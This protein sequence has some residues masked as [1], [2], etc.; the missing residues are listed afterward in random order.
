MLDNGEY[1]SISFNGIDSVTSSFVNSALI[2]LLE[3][4]SF[5]YIKSNMTFKNTN[6][7]VNMIIKKRFD[8]EVIQRPKMEKAI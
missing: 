8:F 6:R 7:E 4:H 3:Y 5:D 1:V 2:E